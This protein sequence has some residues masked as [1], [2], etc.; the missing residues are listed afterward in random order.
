MTVHSMFFLFILLY[1]ST[2]GRI[3]N[4]ALGPGCRCEVPLGTWLKQHAFDAIPDVHKHEAGV[5]SCREKSLEILST[6]H[7]QK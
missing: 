5:L 4:S 7:N 1:N 6:R 3:V 2:E